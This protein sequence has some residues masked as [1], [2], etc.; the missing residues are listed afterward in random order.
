MVQFIGNLVKNKNIK[1]T[2]LNGNERVQWIDYNIFIA[3]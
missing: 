2:D 3:L 1:D